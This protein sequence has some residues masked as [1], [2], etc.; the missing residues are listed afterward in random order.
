MAVV[1]A[2]D[3]LVSRGYRRVLV[4]LTRSPEVER[5]VGTACTLAE[6]RAT[7]TAAVVIEVSSLLPLDARM[8]GEEREARMLLA[9][10]RAVGD[11]HGVRVVPR[12]LR[13]RDACAAILELAG[14]EGSDLL[15][16]GAVRPRLRRLVRHA[17]RKAPCRVLLV[18]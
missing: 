10:A 6:E 17:V 2:A 16:I 14:R 12:V 9:R 5:V 7:V 11:A 15:V 18:A 8:D 1:Q 13:T 3:P 4:P